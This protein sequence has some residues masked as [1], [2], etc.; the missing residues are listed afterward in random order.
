VLGNLRVRLRSQR[1]SGVMR[2][3]NHRA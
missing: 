3:R 2:D 1:T